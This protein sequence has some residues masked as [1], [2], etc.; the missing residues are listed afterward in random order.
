MAKLNDFIMDLEYTV[1]AEQTAP[2]AE[3]IKNAMLAAAV[4]VMKNGT[5]WYRFADGEL[6]TLDNCVRYAQMLA[7]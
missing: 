5:T 3:R 1:T 7:A 6:L 4:P 2:S